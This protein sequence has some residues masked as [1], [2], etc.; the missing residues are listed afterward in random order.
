MN[1]AWIKTKEILDSALGII[2]VF[3]GIWSLVLNWNSAVIAG[4]ML[5][6]LSHIFVKIWWLRFIEKAVIAGI[7]I[8]IGFTGHPIKDACIAILAI[9]TIGAVLTTIGNTMAT[10]EDMEKSGE[11]KNIAEKLNK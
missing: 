10:L 11:L 6:L 9:S 4:A 2:G 5:I 7:G 1:L 8:L 3:I